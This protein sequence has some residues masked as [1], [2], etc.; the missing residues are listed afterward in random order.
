MWLGLLAVPVL[1]F[2]PKGP[3]SRRHAL[4]VATFVWAV[5]CAALF[6]VNAGFIEW[7]AGWTVGP[8]Y[9]VA[10]APFF[11]F[12]AACGMDRIARVH[13]TM[14]AIMRG[15]GG[16]LALASILTIG[17]VSLVFDTLPEN[18]ARPFAQ[19]SIPM[20]I[21]GFVPHHVAEWFG[22]ESTTF[23]YIACGAMLLAPMVASLW[24]THEGRR[25]YIARVLVFVFAL[26][27][28]LVP[29]FYPAPADGSPLF[30][31]FPSTRGFIG[32]WEPPG[33]DRISLL[34]VEAE[35]YGTTRPCLWYQ[36]GDLERIL[37]NE[38][39]AIRDAERVKVPRPDNCS[40]KW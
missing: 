28:G 18:I 21:T 7:R 37:G 35:R 8:R 27:A 13:P 34:R 24:P 25:L 2:S 39:Q 26:A 38:A 3:P 14:R 30:V 4:R 33:R 11:A 16:G 10:C 23:W 22:W 32:G 9:L 40:R 29:A 5:G 15:T 1:I 19:F 17:T 20:M 12:G 36:L 31:L 6:G